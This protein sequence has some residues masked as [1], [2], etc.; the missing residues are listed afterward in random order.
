MEGLDMSRARDSESVRH[1]IARRAYLRFCD[2]GCVPG[3]DLDDW[4]A[5][6]RMVDARLAGKV[7]P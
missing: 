7:A 4:L 1:E 3:A 2:R 5:A 6:E